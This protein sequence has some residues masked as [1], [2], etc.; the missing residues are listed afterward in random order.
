MTEP[1]ETEELEDHLLPELSDLSNL[2]DDLGSDYAEPD[3]ET[4]ALFPD[5]ASGAEEH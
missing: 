5:G 2:P 1:W 3:L 4:Y